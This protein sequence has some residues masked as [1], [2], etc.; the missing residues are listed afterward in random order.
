MF[1]RL[2]YQFPPSAKLSPFDHLR[3]PDGR[4]VNFRAPTAIRIG[5]DSV[6]RLGRGCKPMDRARKHGGAGLPEDLVEQLVVVASPFFYKAIIRP[7]AACLAGVPRGQVLSLFLS[8]IP[9]SLNIPFVLARLLAVVSSPLA[10]LLFAQKPLRR[11][12]RFVGV[13]VVGGTPLSLDGVRRSSLA[14]LP[15]VEPL[16]DWSS[17]TPRACVSGVHFAR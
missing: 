13:V 2:F 15:L 17:E 5:Q 16:F 10:T 12:S 14:S 4:M 6:P 1:S 9:R 8:Q 7:K 11:R 3:L